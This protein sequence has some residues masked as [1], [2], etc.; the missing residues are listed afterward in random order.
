MHFQE[1]DSEVDT[2]EVANVAEEAALAKETTSPEAVEVDTE[3]AAMTTET[4]EDN[5]AVVDA[6]DSSNSIVDSSNSPGDQFVDIPDGNGMASNNGIEHM[7]DAEM[8]EDAVVSEVTQSEIQEE[9]SEPDPVVVEKPE[10]SEKT[11]D[12]NGDEEQT[13]VVK[14]KTTSSD[15]DNNKNHSSGKSKKQKTDEVEKGE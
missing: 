5:R 11:V 2:P 9:K 10:K 3:A 13:S 12:K 7:E 1:E 15:G 8:R 6:S 4:M 14:R